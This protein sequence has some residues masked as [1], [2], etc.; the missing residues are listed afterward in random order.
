[1]YIQYDILVFQLL[2]ADSLDTTV[3]LCL[4]AFETCRFF[5]SQ[6]AVNMTVTDLISTTECG[7]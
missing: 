1:M 3:K 2:V 4:S 6:Q 7:L 5:I